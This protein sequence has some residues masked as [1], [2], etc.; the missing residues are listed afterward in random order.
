MDIT[1]HIRYQEIKKQFYGYRTFE[2]I[3]RVIKRTKNKTMYVWPSLHIHL[4]PQLGT[5]VTI[6]T[7]ACPIT[8]KHILH[9]ITLN[10]TS[11][12]VYLLRQIDRQTSGNVYRYAASKQADR[13]AQICT[14]THR[15]TN[16]HRQIRQTHMHIYIHI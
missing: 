2:F 14:Q 12:P 5:F 1:G 16:L 15:Q 9:R 11:L 4:F 8:H 3:S 7:H 13:H 6:C 10:K